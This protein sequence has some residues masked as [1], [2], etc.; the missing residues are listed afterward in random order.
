MRVMVTRPIVGISFMQVCAVLDASD[1][2]ILAVCNQE[3]P[4][5]VAQGWVK[6]HRE[7]DHG[8]PHQHLGPVPCEEHPE[9]V[10]LL[11]SC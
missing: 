2:E 3:N 11:A 6:V 7:A 5:G 9:R 1:E 4:A 10:H 8:F